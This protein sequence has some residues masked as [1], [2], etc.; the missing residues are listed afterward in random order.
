MKVEEIMSKDVICVNVP[1]MRKKALEL[2]QKNNVSGLPVVEEKSKKLVGMVT[3]DELLKNP[4][5]EQIALVMRRLVVTVESNKDVKEAAGIFLEKN[6][7]RLPVVENGI[8]VGMLTVED[9]IKRGLSSM[10]SDVPCSEYM[11]KSVTAAWEETPLH[12]ILKV[13]DYSKSLCVVLI[14][15]MGQLTGVLDN[16]D[17]IKYGEIVE[18]TDK[19]SMN[20]GAD[21]DDWTWETK[22]TLYI[23]TKRLRLPTKPAKE[24]M[25]GEVVKVSP[26]ATIT[27]CARLMRKH[28]V[29]QLPVIDEDNDIVGILRDIDLLRFFTY[30][31]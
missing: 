24:F 25:T 29:E 18:E 13:M 2:M 10:E 5:E 8:L 14:N 20:K 17:L 3:L 12:L 19:T 28:D 27:E 7:Y 9:V 22:S 26:T 4:D 11:K 30:D 16:S 15:N 21:D 1:G 6:V 23:G 31:V